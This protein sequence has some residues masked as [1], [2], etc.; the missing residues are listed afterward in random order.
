VIG[1]RVI[2]NSSGVVAGVTLPCCR[3][4]YRNLSWVLYR[5]HRRQRRARIHSGVWTTIFL[6]PLFF[7]ISLISS[8]PWPP[9]LVR[10]RATE[11]LAQIRLQTGMHS[12]LFL[13]D[14]FA[15]FTSLLGVL[16]LG[17]KGHAPHQPFRLVLLAS[18]SSS[19]SNSLLHQLPQ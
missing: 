15:S 10:T 3:I 12:L 19:S 9:S 17:D 1:D 18:S 14:H 11:S 5:I 13:P 6:F 8:S 16:Q 7:L 2:L 4:S